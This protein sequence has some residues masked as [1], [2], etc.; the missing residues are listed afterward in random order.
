L[1]D[2]VVKTRGTRATASTLNAVD[3]LPTTNHP[4][5]KVRPGTTRTPFGIPK[6]RNMTVVTWSQIGIFWIDV[7]SAVVALAAGIDAARRS[8]FEAAGLAR[9]IMSAWLREQA[10]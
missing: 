9:R 6:A 7:T 1:K 10:S 2:G 3:T 5:A 4:A 8:S